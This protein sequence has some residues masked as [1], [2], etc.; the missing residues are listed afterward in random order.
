MIKV[1]AEEQRSGATKRVQF[2]RRAAR[3]GA[4]EGQQS[5]IRLVVK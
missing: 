5:L 1:T 2:D 4:A 3:R